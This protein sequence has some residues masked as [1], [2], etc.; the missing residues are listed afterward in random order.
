MIP[1]RLVVYNAAMA[2]LNP[3]N[4]N[5]WIDEHRELL[6]PPIGNAVVW[7]DSEYHV[8]VIGGPNCRRDFHIDPA[9]EFF[10]QLEGD[11]VLEYIDAAGKR[12]RA[13]IKQGDVMLLPANVPH[14]P[15]RGAGSVGMVLERK[16]HPD[17]PDGFAFYCERCD[18]K[19]HETRIG[20][21]DIVADLPNV[22]DGFNAS[23]ALRTCSACSYVQ[24]VAT[25]PRL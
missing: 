7:Q 22:L 8:M 1:K 9:D 19:L 10:H 3:F 15:Q 20:V 2:P 24:P 23:Q 6:K 4:L 17:E 25:G 14:S 16:R 18:N 11:M 21:N 5:R 13:E 12:Q